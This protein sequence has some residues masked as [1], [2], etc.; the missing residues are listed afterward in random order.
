MPMSSLEA[1]P[2]ELIK[3]VAADLPP[4]DAVR[5]AMSCRSVNSKLNMRSLPSRLF[6]SYHHIYGSYVVD[7]PFPTNIRVPMP[8]RTSDRM[9][10]MTLRVKWRSYSYSS[11]DDY[12]AKS[13]GKLWVVGWPTEKKTDEKQ[14][15]EFSGEQYIP[16]CKRSMVT[17]I[18]QV[19]KWGGCIVAEESSAPSGDT[20]TVDLSFA[21][22][23]GWIYNVWAHVGGEV[24]ELH[25][26]KIDLNAIIFDTPNKFLS[27]NYTTLLNA[28]AI[29]DGEHGAQDFED[30]GDCLLDNDEI[31]DYKPHPTAVL[32]TKTLLDQTRTLRQAQKCHKQAP[33]RFLRDLQ[34]QLSATFCEYNIPV[35]E[36]SLEALEDILWHELEELGWH[37]KDL[38]TAI[39]ARIKEKQRER[40]E[41]EESDFDF[42]LFDD[43]WLR[44]PEVS[45]RKKAGRCLKRSLLWWTY[46]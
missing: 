35:V 24:E 12:N 25:L 34:K 9:H 32:L 14:S 42:G 2:S 30:A 3:M 15:E 4:R 17:K 18:D 26:D 10:S 23:E 19:A 1:L 33:S 6:V 39:A 20:T 41:D 28:K 7:H 8:V 45:L 13:K 22:K 5:L 11:Y 21:P 37:E 43:D 40:E 38:E 31:D 16:A 36:E 44:D 27:R 46:L 29:Y